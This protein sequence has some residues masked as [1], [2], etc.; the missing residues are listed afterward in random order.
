MKN[1]KYRQSFSLPQLEIG[2]PT[3]SK[4]LQCH[5]WKIFEISKFLT[6]LYEA[7][8]EEVARSLV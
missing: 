2:E 6:K 7:S 4:L 8:S 3:Y 1:I 5:G